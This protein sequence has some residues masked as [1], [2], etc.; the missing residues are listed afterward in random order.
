MGF[1]HVPVLLDEAV[2]LVGPVPGG[3]YVDCTL[4]GGGHAEA[5]LER[6]APSARLIGLDRDPAALAAASARLER[7]GG[8]FIPVRS[9]FGEVE[10]VLAAQGLSRVDGLVADLGVSSPQLDEASRGFSFLR[11][12]PLDMR[13]DPDQP[14]TAADLVN[15]ADETELARVFF[16]YGEEHQSRRVARAVVRGRPFHRTL[17]LAEV[18]A[19]ALGGRQGRIHPATRC[20]QALRIAVNDELGQLTR[21]LDA[22]PRVLVGGGRAAI[23][24]FHSLEDRLVK[25]RIR[26]WAGLDSE[27]DAYGD[28]VRAPVARMLT[29]KAVGAGDNNPRAR[30]AKLRGVQ[31]L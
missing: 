16:E 18:I 23:I 24:S 21:L 10:A 17:P 8:R 12:G 1:H 30:S 4:G 19:A 22:L 31:F 6:G 11:D 20:F 26:G 2:D 25:H 9:A 15:I 14:T 3:V 28:P 27:R 7:F 29:R 13:M 5:L